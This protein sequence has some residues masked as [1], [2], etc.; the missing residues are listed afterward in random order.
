M[1]EIFIEG[2]FFSFEVCSLVNGAYLQPNPAQ[3]NPIRHLNSRVKLG[4]T[5]S[6]AE[7]FCSGDE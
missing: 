3:N 2:V 5:L 4:R 1:P 6:K 7:R